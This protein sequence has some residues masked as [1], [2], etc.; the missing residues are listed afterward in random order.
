MRGVR[1]V[2]IGL[3]VDVGEIEYHDGSDEIGIAEFLAYQLFLVRVLGQKLR[4]V[5][6]NLVGI[7]DDIIALV[8]GIVRVSGIM[9]LF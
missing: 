8:P 1:S 9:R 2:V 3:A 7:G 6:Q 4:G 5:F